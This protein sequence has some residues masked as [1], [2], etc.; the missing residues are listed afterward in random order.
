VVSIPEKEYKP[1]I[2][3]DCIY[4]LYSIDDPNLML[5]LPKNQTLF[6]TIDALNHVIEAATTKIENPYA[7]MLAKQTIELIYNF[8]P[9]CLKDLENPEPRYYLLYASALAGISFDNGLL[10]F[11]HALEH[12][13]SAIKPELAHGLGLAMILPAVIEAIY[14]AKAEILANIL[15]PIVPSLQGIPGEAVF[16]AAGVEKWLAEMGLPNKLLDEGFSEND[17]DKL[18]ELAMNTPSLD[19]LLSMAPID[20]DKNTVSR[21]YSRSLKPIN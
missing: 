10:H 13:L 12:P 21:I 20:A 11:T 4:P 6:V 18:T 3:Y 9:E 5:K 14:P 15:N 1:A 19:L 8:L 7:I 2:A 17:I 16:A